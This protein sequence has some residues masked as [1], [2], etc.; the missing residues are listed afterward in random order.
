MFGANT[1][2]KEAN[3][4]VL[5]FIASAIL[6]A[7]ASFYSHLYAQNLEYLVEET[8]NPEIST[9]FVR[10]CEEEECPPNE[11]TEFRTL[12]VPA[13]IFSKCK[14]NSCIDA[15][16]ESGA[17]LEIMCT[18]EESTCAGPDTM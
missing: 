13:G 18:D 6:V 1:Q 7:C 2:E 12:V 15:C 11:L 8:C 9:C 17:C 10:D 14:E 5:F 4:Y 16:R 3:F